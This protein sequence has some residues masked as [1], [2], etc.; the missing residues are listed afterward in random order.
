MQE[1]PM[2]G[3]ESLRIIE[4]MINTAKSHFTEDGHLYLLWGWI[5]ALCSVGD[6]LLLR[7]AQVPWHSVVWLATWVAL[8]YQFY[9][10]RNKRRRVRVRT[11]TDDILVSIWIAFVIALMLVTVLLGNIYNAIGKDFYGFLNPIILV[12]YGIPTF[13]CGTILKF[14]PLV[15][16]AIGCWVLSVVTPLLPEAEQL[17]MPAAG[18]LI[19]WIIPGYMVRARYRQGESVRHGL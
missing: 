13:L 7:F 5:V 17:L 3:Q 16:G 11:Y 12:L 2:S 19:A 15:L 8:G 14:R 10:I 9:Y 6:Y 1:E 4:E 18:M